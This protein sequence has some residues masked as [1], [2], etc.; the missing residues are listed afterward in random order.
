MMQMGYGGRPVAA[1]PLAE[2]AAEPPAAPKPPA[3]APAPPNATELVDAKLDD[4]RPTLQAKEK[5]NKPSGRK[6]IDKAGSF[7]ARDE[8]F[9]VAG[10]PDA[11]AGGKLLD[12][13]KTNGDQ[14]A[15]WW[16]IQFWT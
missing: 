6:G 2:A 3:V 9:D 7:L 4:L 14:G 8:G 15:H 16:G 1:A 10:A 5:Q 13:L 12:D 11:P